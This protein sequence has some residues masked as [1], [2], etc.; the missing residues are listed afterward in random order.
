MKSLSTLLMLLLLFFWGHAQAEYTVKG[1][2]SNMIDGA[3]VSDWPVVATLH[4]DDPN[5]QLSIMGHTNAD[6]FYSITFP[7]NAGSDVVEIKTYSACNGVTTTLKKVKELL[8]TLV[9]ANFV[10]CADADPTSSCLAEI[11]SLAAGADPFGRTFSATLIN[12]NATIDEYFWEFG[13]GET[14]TDANPTHLYEFPG[15]YI[16]SL[17]IV[18]ADGCT[19]TSKYVLNLNNGNDCNNVWI[20]F[21]KI[22]SLKF[23]FDGGLITNDTTFNSI[24]E[25]HWEFGDGSFSNDPVPYHTYE[26]HGFYIVTLTLTTP[27]G[28]V[29]QG[30]IF[31]V[32]NADPFPGCDAQIS[33][34]QTNTFHFEFVSSS[35]NANGAVDVEAYKW[36]FGDNEISDNPNPSHTYQEQ[37]IYTVVLQASTSDDCEAYDSQVVMALSTEV[38]TFIYNCQALFENSYVGGNNFTLAFKD[39]SIGGAS[40]WNW[41]F[42]DGSFSNDQHPTHTY[43]EP[44][45]YLVTLQIE[46]I[47]GCESEIGFEIYVG[48]EFPFTASFGCQA[49]F[50]PIPDSIGGNGIQFINLSTSSQ[51]PVEY[52]WDF[53][54]GSMSSEQHPYHEYEEVG[55]YTVS[56]LLETDSCSSYISFEVN[57]QK[58]WN[59]YKKPAL[60]NQASQTNL[61]TESGIFEPVK[62]F[63][64]PSSGDLWIDL[65]ELNTKRVQMTLTDV[66]GRPYI[67]QEF[68]PAFG[69]QRY[70]LS[71]A[72]LA[73]GFYFLRLE[74]DQS[75]RT[76]KFIRQD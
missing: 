53:G 61:S 13:D 65:S 33:Y 45:L 54:D 34:E 18:S 11:T 16:V 15:L 46:T 35:F 9:E 67:I 58:P 71:V 49:M 26:A 14:S 73:P 3:P 24:Y 23:Q 60:L 76:F 66:S 37:G 31:L 42:G 48:A 47:D 72:D 56:L 4:P 20:T 17:T 30:M 6:G 21:D 19:S 1:Y 10:V 27:N 41:D 32:T 70:F 69:P 36:D 7:D 44:G 39:K 8:G 51:V 2:V 22:D 43:V 74:A 75:V 59:Y 63:P 52:L 38:D 5:S 57:S 64:N 29:C 55:E 50:I 68:T 12:A 28:I 25:Y 40:S 62:I